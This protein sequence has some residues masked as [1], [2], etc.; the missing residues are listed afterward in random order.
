MLIL[1]VDSR[2]AVRART[3]QFIQ[4]KFRLEIL[5]LFS[6]LQKPSVYFENFP[7]GQTK[8]YSPFYIP[9]E[10]QISGIFELLVKRGL[11]VGFFKKIHD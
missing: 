9:T 7:A 5:D 8:L 3:G 2:G 1:T 4:S 11:R 10:N 6:R